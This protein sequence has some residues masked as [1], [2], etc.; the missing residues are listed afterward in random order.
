M[1]QYLVFSKEESGDQ[2]PS[3]SANLSFTAKTTIAKLSEDTA[4]LTDS[5]DENLAVRFKK[6]QKH[7]HLI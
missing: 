7:L 1:K 6:S 2:F 3:S 5:K 4:L